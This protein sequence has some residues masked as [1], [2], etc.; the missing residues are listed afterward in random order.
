MGKDC[1]E[2][3]ELVEF[4]EFERG[5]ITLRGMLHSPA[6]AG[7][8]PGVVI[9]HGFTGNR[10][11]NGFVYVHTSRALAR[12]GV[13][14][15]RFD[16]AGSGESEGRFEDM[17]VLTELEDARTALEFLGS[18]E[19]VDMAR[20]GVL[21]HSVGGFVAAMLLEDA[22]LSSGVLCASVA[23]K[24]LFDAGAPPDADEQLDRQGYVAI[25]PH[26]IGRRF[27]EDAERADSL[28]CLARSR[29]DVLV[30]HGE[31]DEA[32]PPE[33][34]HLLAGAAAGR[35]GAR[36]EIVMVPE[37]DHGFTRLAHREELI[38]RTVEWFA[39]TLGRSG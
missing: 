33:H 11:G 23:D 30:M 28:G 26:R 38:R 35:S 9:L 2:S 8:A 19:G 12:A 7:P 16:F 20:L 1:E 24:A 15:L 18:R 37:A 39:S 36:T 17:S 6:G 34:A 3:V 32:V 27:G 29:A 10:I 22:R 25:G 13:A 31:A 14:S 21:G 4:A 5:G